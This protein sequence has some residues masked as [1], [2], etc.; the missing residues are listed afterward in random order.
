MQTR[1]AQTVRTFDW[2]Q[3]VVYFGFVLIFAVFAITLS[4]SGFLT[5]NNLLNI[6]RQTAVISVM[7]VA[8]TFVIACGAK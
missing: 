7:A 3:Y 8:V 5:I 6:V 1:S 2:R 4:D